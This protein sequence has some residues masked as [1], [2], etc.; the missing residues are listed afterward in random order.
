MCG[1]LKPDLPAC[2]QNPRCNGQVKGRTFL[3][4]IRRSQ[5]H[6]Y[7]LHRETKSAVADSSPHPFRGLPD[8]AVGQ[9]DYL[10]KGQTI[11]NIRFHL[12]QYTVNPRYTGAH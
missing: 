2:L 3:A 7:P 4:H 11:G 1:I 9:P 6:R 5:I 12:H 10:E 8:G